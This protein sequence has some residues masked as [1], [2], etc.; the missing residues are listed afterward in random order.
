MM[1]NTKCRISAAFSTLTR[2]TVGITVL[3]APICIRDKPDQS[4]FGSCYH[5]YARTISPCGFS[6]KAT[7]T[8]GVIQ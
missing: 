5:G 8:G 1:P 4:I 3:H 7:S 6:T 2:T